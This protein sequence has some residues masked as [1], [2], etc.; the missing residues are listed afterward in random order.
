MPK[1]RSSTNSPPL[2]QSI[3]LDGNTQHNA[4]DVPVMR[5]RNASRKQPKAR[6]TPRREVTS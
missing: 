4:D 6:P 2:Q 3:Y 1:G 5:K